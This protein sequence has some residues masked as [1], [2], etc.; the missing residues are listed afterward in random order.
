M[1]GDLTVNKATP[2][3]N[4]DR[5]D[6]S[7]PT[8]IFGKNNGSIRWRVQLG[9]ALPETGSNVGSAFKIARYTDAGA[10]IDNPLSIWR[11]TGNVYTRSPIVPDPAV[12]SWTAAQQQTARQAVYAAPFDAMAYNGMQVNGAMEV[13]QE[14]GTASTVGMG[15]PYVVDG[16]RLVNNATPVVSASQV[17][18][19][20]PGLTNSV[21]IVVATGGAMASADQIML[22]N[23]I[24][25]YRI[26]RLA[27]GTANAQPLSIAFWSKIHRPGTYSGSIG[28][29]PNNR[30][31][32]FNFTQNVADAWECKTV[33]IPGDTLG[34][35]VW[36]GGNTLGFKVA[37]V[38]AAGTAHTAPANAWV[39]GAGLN[40]ASGTI[41]GAAATTDTFQITGLIVLPGLELPSAA[42]SP[43][44]MRP[45][46]QELL[47][48]QRYLQRRNFIANQ[49]IATLQA[50]N[51]TQAN[52][53]LFTFPVEMRVNPLVSTSGSA[54]F[55]LQA[56]GGGGAVAGG[57]TIQA[58]TNSAW[59]SSITASGLI[60]G[61]AVALYANQS[62]WM[63]F[64]ARL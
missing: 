6:G 3:I 16:W 7:T 64:D 45:Y 30:F 22:A 17:A 11:D 44:I 61:N 43:F 9:D 15:G 46:D 5:P 12:G 1:T 29:G 32:S 36:T 18:D 53:P 39:T 27:W 21:K 25:G 38:M 48:C 4:L 62:S 10:L 42:Q 28:N 59:T 2:A 58:V 8:G 37:F 60:A 50:Y 56:A 33:T 57:A 23:Y 19:A 26:A 52:G 31:Y 14:L 47:T 55:T 40:G 63:Q 41:N 54:H 35:G 51:T 24:E 20:P 13:S 34:G 49:L